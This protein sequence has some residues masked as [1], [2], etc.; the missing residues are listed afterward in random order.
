[1]LLACK[2]MGYSPQKYT[3]PQHPLQKLIL[4][5]IAA[6]SGV[7]TSTLK[8]GTDGCGLP[9]YCLPLSAGA[10]IY[11]GLA[12]P[13]SSDLEPSHADALH[14]IGSGMASAP[15]MVAGIGRF[16][17][18][19]TQVTGGRMIA[20]EGADG[21]F[22]VAVRG[23]VAL[24]LALKVADGS[25]RIRDIVVLDILRQLGCLSASELEELRSF[26]K[27]ELRSHR[28]ATV[29]EILPDVEM[30]RVK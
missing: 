23:P 1:M 20:K 30:I 12:D 24:G 15:E 17:T 5:A 27:V 14:I 10:R 25:E 4:Q 18:E 21:A 29:G 28:G 11:A 22:G 6:V 2:M 26:I 8:L 9:T 3:S 13:Q 7:S 16:A 19:L